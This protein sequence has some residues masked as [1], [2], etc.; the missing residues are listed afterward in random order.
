[1][2]D[3]PINSNFIDFTEIKSDIDFEIFACDL[4]ECMGYEII[5]PPG[6]GPDGGRDAIVEETRRG[7]LADSKI[8]YLVSCKHI[9]S[10]K[11]VGTDVEKNVPARVHKHHCDA[12]LGVY[13]TH[14]SNQFVSDCLGW[15]SNP[16]H[17][18]S[19]EIL[20]GNGIR[21]QLLDLPSGRRLVQQ[22]FPR[23]ALDH[24]RM[25]TESNIYRKR[26]IFHCA[27]CGV[28]IL[29]RHQGKIVIEA[30][31]APAIQPSRD[32]E[33][34]KRHR[35]NILALHVFCPAHG[36]TATRHL[37]T[38]SKIHDLADLLEPTAFMDLVSS[39]LKGMY[40]WPPHFGSED[41]FIRWFRLVNGLFYFVA[42]GREPMLPLEGMAALHFEHFG[43]HWVL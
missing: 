7:N 39:G 12:F 21:K 33:R 43:A 32:A 3:V 18:F 36:P 16:K 5:V 34:D 22:Y 40:F 41:A 17:G 4:L 13:S 2:K 20:D 30:T 6:K 8:R 1:M 25:Q 27:D 10:G 28:D 19:S 23:A 15:A 24:Q 35:T 14:V 29:E 37:P 26:P 31:H 11:S 38:G 9:T 42:R